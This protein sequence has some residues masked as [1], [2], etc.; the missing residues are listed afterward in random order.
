MNGIEFVSLVF[1]VDWWG[2]WTLY[3]RAY[4]QQNPNTAAGL[5][6]RY[7]DNEVV[8]TLLE[9]RFFWPF[10][11]RYWKMYNDL[12]HTLDRAVGYGIEYGITSE[13][14]ESHG[15]S[16]YSEVFSSMLNAL[17]ALKNKTEG[18]PKNGNVQL[19]LDTDVEALVKLFPYLKGIADLNFINCRLSAD[20]ATV[21]AGQLHV[22]DTLKDLVLTYNTI[23]DEGVEAIAETF[24]HLKELQVLNI[25]STSITDVGGRAM[26]NRLLALS[27]SALAK[28][29]ANMTR[30]EYVSMWPITCNST[31][32]R[33]AARQVRDAVHTLAGQDATVDE[34]INK[35]SEKNKIPA[36]TQRVL[37]A[38]KQLEYGQNK[39]LSDYNMEDES[40]L[41]VVLRL[42]GGS[43]T[44]EDLSPPPKRLDE[45]VE[46]TE[47]ISYGAGKYVF[48]CPYISP[49][50]A[51]CGK[52]WTYLEVRRLAVLTADE[53]KQFET[54]I[55]DNYLRK[56]MGIQ[57]CPKCH[58]LCERINKKH[59]R[60]VCPLCSASDGVEFH[61]CWHCLH[62]WVG[63]GIE[64]CG[65]DS[66]GGEDPRLKILRDCKK[67]T[68][69]GV[70]NCPAVR[71]C[72]KC[73]MLIEHEKAC[74]HMDCVCGQKFCFICLKPAVNGHYQCGM[75]N[76]PC[77]I[78]DVQKTIPANN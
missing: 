30:L 8:M 1:P 76:S 17:E 49:G 51:Y 55:S 58:S 40:T 13:Y 21:L 26:A 6:E 29:F 45:D 48:K 2:E 60:V 57:E 66:C 43:N 46:T 71:A 36:E 5:E 22:L 10:V 47:L 23:G 31:S 59:K 37:Y 77:E 78:A 52:E 24:P 44:V 39:Y 20:A 7:P 38:S 3:I 75:Y 56:G 16:A 41:F 69:V 27:V 50:G 65:N 53:K 61:F 15:P 4:F 12:P 73:G 19:L 32:L 72:L 63:G 35:I 62:Q 67:K 25:A 70:A 42:R 28:A 54:K 34:L 18:L 9:D 14:M 33:M 64:K 74:K 68:I 11:C